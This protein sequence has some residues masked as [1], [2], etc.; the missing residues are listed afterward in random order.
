MACILE[1]CNINSEIYPGFCCS[2]VHLHAC[3]LILYMY[4]Y[5]QLKVKV[6]AL[7]DEHEVRGK[8]FFSLFPVLRL[9]V[10]GRLGTLV[11]G[12]RIARRCN[13]N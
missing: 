5:I 9:C 1:L 8:F 6:Y 3:A 13:S 11:M 7:S 10:F 4:M 2:V 12:Q